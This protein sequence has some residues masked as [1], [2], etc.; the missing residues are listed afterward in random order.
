MN[1]EAD[2]TTA[3]NYDDI[4]QEFAQDRARRKL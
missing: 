1:I 4:I 3:I 2:V